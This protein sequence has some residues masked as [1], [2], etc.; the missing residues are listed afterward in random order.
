VNFPAGQFDSGMEYRTLNVYH[1][2]ISA[3]HPQFQA[4]NV[5]E[6]HLVVQLLIGIFNSRPIMPRYVTAWDVD[7]VTKYLGTK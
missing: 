7:T 2:A 1:S 6:H 4:F 3:T 5:G